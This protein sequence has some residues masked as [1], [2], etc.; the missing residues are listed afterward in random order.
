MGEFQYLDII[1][2]A[3]VAGFLVL[4]C[5]AFSVGGQETN[6]AATFSRDAR[7]LFPTTLRRWLNRTSAPL[8][9]RAMP[10]LPTSLPKG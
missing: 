2:F 3:M 9:R 1:L 4:V 8:G 5:A 10:L 6:A 7:R